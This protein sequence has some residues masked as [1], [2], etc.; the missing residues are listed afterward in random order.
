MK[1]QFFNKEWCES[2][3]SSSGGLSQEITRWLL[4]F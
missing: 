2:V 1:N 3:K 4:L